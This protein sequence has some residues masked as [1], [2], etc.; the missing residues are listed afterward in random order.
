M[1]EWAGGRPDRRE[2]HSARAEADIVVFDKERPIGHERMLHAGA[3]DDAVAGHVGNSIVN[4][5]RWN[6]RKTTFLVFV[7]H[8]GAATLDIEQRRRL[9]GKADSA[10]QRG[11]PRDPAAIDDGRIENLHALAFHARPVEHAL[12]TENPRT[13]LIV[14]ADLSAADSAIRGMG[15][16]L[17]ASVAPLFPRPAVANVDAEV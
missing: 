2:S 6:D 10:G 17:E 1:H 12:D 15:R 9:H 3:D 14:A 7:A 8:P 13:G 4:G 16:K 11:E 5:H